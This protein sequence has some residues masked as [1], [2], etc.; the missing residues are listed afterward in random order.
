M[1]PHQAKAIAPVLG[2][3]MHSC[4]D[5]AVSAEL[6]H[7]SGACLQLLRALW[8][9]RNDEENELDAS[10]A[11]HTLESSSHS[12]TKSIQSHQKKRGKV[13]PYSFDLDLGITPLSKIENSAGVRAA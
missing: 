10:V 13:T 4:L 3:Y 12:S 11:S 2:L 9:F 1:T 6:M 7:G 5:Q 8:L